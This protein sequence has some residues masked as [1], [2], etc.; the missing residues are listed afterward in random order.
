MS[1]L[2]VIHLLYRY[3]AA[4]FHQIGEFGSQGMGNLNLTDW[5]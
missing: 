3:A 2:P 4:G 5:D 1:I